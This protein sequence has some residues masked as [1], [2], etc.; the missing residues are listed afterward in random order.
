MFRFKIRAIGEN[1]AE[2]PKPAATQ[3]DKDG[4][5]YVHNEGGR[6]QFEQ[7]VFT[8]EHV[9]RT[10]TYEFSEVIPEGATDNKDGTY[11][12]DGMKY[13]GQTYKVEFAVTSE[14]MNGKPTVKVVKTYKNAKG[15]ARH[16]QV[17]ILSKMRHSHLI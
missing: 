13:D 2:A 6:V 10:W 14:E 17:V 9:N 1:A 8:A 11:T 5:Y 12:L 15:E 7:F 3:P 4:Y 16:W